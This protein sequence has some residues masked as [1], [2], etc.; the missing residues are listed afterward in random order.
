VAKKVGRPKKVGAEAPAQIVA[1]RY[2]KGL[3]G[4]LD[5]WRKAQAGAPNR[6][7]AVR[8]LTE[9]ALKAAGY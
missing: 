8:Q 1:A 3:L 5:K 6:S 7:E 4:R 9:I 2:S